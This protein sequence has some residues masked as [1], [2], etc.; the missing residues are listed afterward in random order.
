MIVRD[1]E[2]GKLKDPFDIEK[3]YVFHAI[4]STSEYRDH[5]KLHELEIEGHKVYYGSNIAIYPASYTLGLTYDYEMLL[6]AYGDL[7]ED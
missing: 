1:I 3:G 5:T 7:M 6:N 4:K 2:R